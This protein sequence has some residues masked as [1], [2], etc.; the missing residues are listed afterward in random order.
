MSQAVLGVYP[1]TPLSLIRMMVR[2]RRTSLMEP[3]IGEVMRVSYL[4][5]GEGEGW[6]RGGE[7]SVKVEG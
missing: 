1:T 3:L 6:R 2:S 4:Q 5:R 7:E